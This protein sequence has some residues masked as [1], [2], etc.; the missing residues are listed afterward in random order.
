MDIPQDTK[1]VQTPNGHSLTVK[2][3]LT[4]E[5]K[6]ANRR[7]ALALESNKDNVADGIDK[8]ED[9]LITQIV[10][11]L[12]GSNENIVE[13]V[14]KLPSDDYDLLINTVNDIQEGELGEDG[15]K[16]ELTSS[17]STSPSSE[18]KA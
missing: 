6:R 7:I 16:K 9:S 11:D 18:E 2:A 10:I 5:D 13:R 14:L 15:K 17:G 8:L 12:D 1:K 3:Y 4:G